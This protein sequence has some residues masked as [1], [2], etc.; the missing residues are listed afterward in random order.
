MKKVQFPTVQGALY[1][2]GKN[3]FIILL[4]AGTAG[5]EHDYYCSETELRILV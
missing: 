4:K 1:N 3:N 2:L 5:P